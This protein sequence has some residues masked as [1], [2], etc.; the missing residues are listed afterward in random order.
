MKQI[1]FSPEMV[2][3]ILD[4]RKTQFRIPIKL[5]DN[6]LTYTGYIVNYTDK[7][8]CG[9]CSFGIVKEMDLEY[10]K[11]KYK[12]NDV[13][14][15][16][17]SAKILD[18]M[19][20]DAHFEI[21]YQF[22]DGNI[23]TLTYDDLINKHKLLQ[24]EFENKY[25]SKSYMNNRQKVPNGCLKE[26]SRIFLKVTNVKVDR[27][28]DISIDSIEKEGYPE[29][30]VMCSFNYNDQLS[31]FHNQKLASFVGKD[32]E[33]AL[34]HDEIHKEF[35]AKNKELKDNIYSWWINLWNSTAKEG[36]K[37][38]DNPYVFV[39]GFERIQQ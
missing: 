2:K 24:D 20:Y 39:Y 28:Q 35:Y 37:W 34:Y 6:T 36:Y 13:L 21:I 19:D 11:H 7:K 18:Y 9:K 15:V 26:M 38:E 31:R 27:L 5:K 3:A 14:W 25:L 4:G 8:R 32:N 30:N 10:I 23:G 33:K 22:A 17:E 1:L 16:R 29:K 12:I